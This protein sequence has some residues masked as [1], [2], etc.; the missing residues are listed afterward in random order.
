M[1]LRVRPISIYEITIES[2]MILMSCR[3]VSMYLIELGQLSVTRCGIAYK[4]L[5]TSYLWPCRQ[6]VSHINYDDYIGMLILD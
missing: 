3:P 5:I 2:S 4:L 6:N 1:V